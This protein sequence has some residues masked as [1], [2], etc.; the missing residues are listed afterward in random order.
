MNR[1][2]NILRFILAVVLIFTTFLSCLGRVMWN[3]VWRTPIGQVEP[4]N[5][6]KL[7]N[8]VAVVTNDETTLAVF[9][10][11][12][13]EAL[14]EYSTEAYF[15]A[16][17]TMLAGNIYIGDSEGSIHSLTSQGEL[18]FTFDGGDSILTPLIPWGNKLY[19]SDGPHLRCFDPKGKDIEW[20]FTVHTGEWERLIRSPPA[21]EDG[22]LYFTCG[23]FFY[24]LDARSGVE[25]WR[26][27]TTDYAVLGV[28][29]PPVFR[30]DKV[31][32]PNPGDRLIALYTAD[33]SLAWEAHIPGSF[34]EQPMDVALI[35]Q[36]GKVFY[37]V[38]GVSTYFQAEEETPKLLEGIIIAQ[39]ADGGDILWRKKVDTFSRLF[40]DH[41]RLFAVCGNKLYWL[42]LNDGSERASFEITSNMESPTIRDGYLFYY[43]PQTSDLV[44]VRL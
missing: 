43:D 8:L 10:A 41:N 18:R 44:G 12:S 20:S 14:W 28:Y 42:N 24:C 26:Y 22:R 16:P 30:E 40:W 2:S 38:M 21:I 36:R 39:S 4:G 1:N 29:H 37:G 17:P 15:Y 27:Q 5:I 32:V 7:G 31:I 13:G 6:A 23:E 33:G 35:C 3:E 11:G 19:F 25:L 9:D 34:W